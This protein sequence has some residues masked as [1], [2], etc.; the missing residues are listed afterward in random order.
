MGFNV[1][2]FLLGF[3]TLLYFTYRRV[4]HGQH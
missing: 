3:T 2:L 4:W 1:I